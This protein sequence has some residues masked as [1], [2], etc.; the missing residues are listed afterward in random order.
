MRRCANASRAPACATRRRCCT[1][2][3]S[4]L[5]LP[6]LFGGATLWLVDPAT[7]WLYPLAAAT[8]GYLLPW[9]YINHR[10]RQYQQSIH[11]ALPDALNLLTVY[12]R[13]GQRHRPQLR[14]P[15]PSWR[16]SIRRW[17]TNCASSSTRRAPANRAAMRCATS[18][19]APASMTCGRS[20][21][22]CIRPSG[23]GPASPG[24]AHARA[25]VPDQAAP[26]RRGARR[27]GQRQAGISARP[28]SVS[29]ALRGVFWPGG[30][31]HL[32]RAV[33]S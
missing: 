16:W 32:P 6:V 29:R 17:P 24:T 23:S 3:A 22:C 1:W 30:R 26:A 13:G 25:A 10:T 19:T 33:L 4:R 14:A 28:L 5:V 27:E 2:H 8:A 15:R 20:P 12:R 21:R 9:L 31:R 7:E 11:N 18:L